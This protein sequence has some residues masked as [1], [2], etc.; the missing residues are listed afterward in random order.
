MIL[1]L[2]SP[3]DNT[4]IPVRV[5]LDTGSNST[6]V[7]KNRSSL[8]YMT[9][10]G[11]QQVVL[12]A[13]G[14][15]AD[16]KQRD[17]YVL[18]LAIS[19]TSSPSEKFFPIQAIGVDTIAGPIQS[20][21]ITDYESSFITSNHIVLADPETC[22]TGMLKIDILVGQDYYHKLVK[23]DK[24]Y[25]SG[26]LV[27]VP[28]ISGY[29][30]AGEVANSEISNL[31]ESSSSFSINSV[32]HV[33]SFVASLPDEINDIKQFSSLE[34][35]GIGPLEAEISP[36]LDRFNHTTT[37]NGERYSVILPKRPKRLRKLP[38]NGLYTFGRL[39]S[40]YANLSKA[41]REEDLKAYSNIMTEQLESN[42]L[43][44]VT[45]IGEVEEAK[46]YLANDPLALDKIK[47]SSTDT[48]THYLPHFGVKKKSNNKLR[49]VY[50]AAAK[51]SINAYSLNSCLETGPDLMNSLLSILIRFRTFPYALKSDIRKAF[52]Q[53]EIDEGDRDLLR[54]LWIEHGEVWIYRFARLPFGL[55]CAPFILAAT[56]KKHLASSGL[57][58]EKQH[59]IFRSFYVDDNVMGTNTLEELVDLKS[60][61][62][63]LFEEAG[64]TLTQF[65][66]NHPEMRS[67]LSQS[68]PELPKKE[69]VLGVLWDLIEDTLSINMESDILPL[70]P[71][72][73]KT[74][75]AH[76]NT[77]RGVYSRIGQTY[78]PLGLLSPFI[79]MGKLILRD[80]C[81]HVKGWD[82][83]LP[84]KYLEAWQK[85]SSQLPY[86]N[87]FSVP[88]YVGLLG[89]NSFYLAGFCDASILG[90]AA[91][92]YYIAKDDKGSIVSNLLVSKTRIA[93]QNVKGIPRL[94]LCGALL[95]CNLMANVKKDLPE[96]QEQNCYYFTDSTCVLF[97]LK[98]ESYDWPVFVANRLKQCL[99]VSSMDNWHHVATEMNPA[100]LPSRGCL[101]STLCDDRSKRKLF[102]EGPDFLKDDLSSY[103]SSVDVK[104]MPPGCKEELGQISL[105][106]ITLPN[107]VDISSVIDVSK[108]NSY[109]KLIRVTDLV[110]KA[111]D[112]LA[113]KFLG[114]TRSNVA[115]QTLQNEY[116]H[117]RKS[118]ILWIRSS[119]SI[120][121]KDF[122]TLAN[123]Y[124]KKKQSAFSNISHVTR[125]QFLSMNV[126]LDKE[127]NVLRSKSR[128]QDSM[129]DYATSNP[130]ILPPESPF[131]TLLI[132]DTHERLLHAGTGQT[133]AAI[134]SEFWIPRLNRIA[135]KVLN[136]CVN[137]KKVS[138]PAYPLPPHADLPSYRAQ[139]SRAFC[140]VGIDFAGPFPTRERFVDKSFEDYKSYLLI[141]TCASSRAV[142]FEA[143]NT[144][145]TYDFLMALKRFVG[146]RG[147]PDQLVSDN[148][149]TF[150]CANKKLQTIYR[151]RSVNKYLISER[152]EW[153]FYTE[154]AAWKGGFIETIVKMFKKIAYKVF[155]GHHLSYEEF[156]TVVKSAQGIINSRPLTYLHK[157]LK[158]GIPLTPSMLVHGF[159]L[160][161]LPPHGTTGKDKV[162][163]RRMEL[164]EELTPIQRYNLLESVLDAFWNRYSKE[165]LTELNE[166]HIRQRVQSKSDRIPKVGDICLLRQENTPRRHWPLATI[167][168]VDISP[169]DG[170]VRT[171][172]VRTLNESGNITHLN[173][174]PCF[175]IPLEEDV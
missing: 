130:I 76:K 62:V 126:F 166:R 42:V 103:C 107:L 141:F 63:D 6:F 45:C 129:L 74:V 92:V 21:A 36:V 53:I 159:N 96:I 100:D 170:K 152:I 101:L 52:L 17:I 149:K 151:D 49:L 133:V 54:T 87:K 39:L 26:G 28:T 93:P 111:I 57:S 125:N 172:G 122:F 112:K 117:S 11:Q 61:M 165:Y 145:N 77:K 4:R 116:S 10:I 118:E 115:K 70:G 15:E 102:Y 9:K 32:N 121:Y 95:L 138:G 19:P 2:K 24:L 79:F 66:S 109:Q 89:A 47:V 94:E 43:E 99:Q 83:K 40:N 140:H 174:S 27:L 20:F 154:R 81:D 12:Q 132:R 64:M 142:H 110:L 13:F 91:C 162:V 46:R 106:S 80:I 73:S 71:G 35:L 98:S 158:D 135:S 161:D 147:A 18:N 90:F 144:L 75:K 23:G 114:I 22:N 127:L 33:S 146:E 38:S 65:N 41:G 34:N 155:G 1:W 44:R 14:K 113:Y 30:L 67:I 167:E 173:R 136:R 78:D 84:D 156:R 97:W 123:G 175:L 16:C 60:S 55:T 163:E 169:R 120:Y 137:C 8:Q 72:K 37:H 139:R 51:S 85:W 88:R 124:S 171:V 31:E 128:L 143:T 69:P 68:E 153:T 29:C 160:T 164:A 148:A 108:F 86:L 104:I 25:V 48:P 157:G 58:P 119:Q 150:L 59:D 105:P 131:T 7:L 5:L 56:L 3:I 50:D 82:S 168:R 134:R